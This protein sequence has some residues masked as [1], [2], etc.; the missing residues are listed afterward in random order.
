MTT[1]F[2]ANPISGKTGNPLKNSWANICAP[3][4][5]I[6]YTEFAGHGSVLAADA[7]RD[8]FD[9]IIA[10]GGDGT[11]NDIAS[12]LINTDTTFGVVPTGSGN[13]FARSIGLPASPDKLTQVFR[14]RATRIIDVGQIGEDLFFCAAGV[15]LEAQTAQLFD[16]SGRRGLLQY[17]LSALKA[18]GK[19]EDAK[20]IVEID[21]RPE[22]ISVFNLTFANMPQ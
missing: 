22:K 15:G 18:Y 3:D 14:R 20:L 1:L 21:G 12:S 16:Q 4:D 9:T 19:H 5:V 17:C 6:R 10:V 2:I 7:V 11:V 8:G 13:G